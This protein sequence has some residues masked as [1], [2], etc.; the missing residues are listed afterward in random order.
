I[1]GDSPRAPASCDEKAHRSYR[2]WPCCPRWND[3]NWIARVPRARE[4]RQ[5]RRCDEDEGS[6]HEWPARLACALTSVARRVRRLLRADGAPGALLL[7]D[8][9]GRSPAGGCPHGRDVREGF[10]APAGVSR[11]ER[12]PGGRVA[13]EDRTQRAGAALA[14]GGRRGRRRTAAGG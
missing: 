2:Q 5:P 11:R 9:D 8:T 10:R 12:R 6:T 1:A 13:V 14:G 4:P 3:R 7:C